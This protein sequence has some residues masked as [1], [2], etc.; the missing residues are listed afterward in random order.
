MESNS[1]E[2]F[3]E[4]RTIGPDFKIKNTSINHID[5]RIQLWDMSGREQFRSLIRPF[6]RNT[7]AIFFVVDLSLKI[8]ISLDA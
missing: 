5:C 7:N 8:E 3:S 4:R 6:Y 1:I 2:K